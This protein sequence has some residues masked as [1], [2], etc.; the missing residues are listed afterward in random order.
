MELLILTILIL[1]TAYVVFV[2]MFPKAVPD[3]QDQHTKEV[4]S[5]I[6]EEHQREAVSSSKA[7][8]L[9]ASLENESAF[10]RGFY[11]LPMLRQ[12]YSLLLQAGMGES[13]A[14]FVGLFI[15]AILIASLVLMILG[16]GLLSLVLGP[17]LAYLVLKLYL[18]RHIH[19]R[20]HDFIMQ[21]ADVLDMFV[22]SLRS[23]FPVTTAFK[24]VAE[25][26]EP[27]VSQEFRQVNSE[28]SMG[29]S[30][31]DALTRLS[32]RIDEPD[33]LFFVV[34]MK[35]Q[36]ETGGN[37]S[38][39]INNLSQIIRKRKQLRLKIRAMTSEGRTTAYILGSMP[40][41]IFGLLY[42]INQ[43]FISILWTSQLG[44]IMLGT[45]AAL[46]VSCFFVVMNM[47]DL[48]I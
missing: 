12:F 4:L 6:Y 7:T 26:M 33:V 40:L 18:K 41:I 37:L 10:V 47:L 27:P 35:V 22:R 48:D 30:V 28:I 31:H 13:A 39:I 2:I 23:G 34:V 36:Q 19:Q 44:L 32:Q 1:I 9:R 38:E 29:Q 11:S 14:S 17:V 24:M 16:Q 3:D 25:N 21:F 42:F 45:A 46:V 5:R 20:N 43:E 15:V 8:Y